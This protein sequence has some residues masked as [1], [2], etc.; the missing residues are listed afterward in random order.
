M[1]WLMPVYELS[2]YSD[3]RVKFKAEEYCLFG[4]GE[5]HIAPEVVD[6]LIALSRQL[7]FLQAHDDVNMDDAGSW[8][9]QIRDGIDS[10]R[11]EFVASRFDTLVQ[12]IYNA[13]HVV[14]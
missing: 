11:F 13:T 14:R 7:H 8:V 4:D 10:N 12:A 9:L 6:S 2:I 5:G 1:F 3:G